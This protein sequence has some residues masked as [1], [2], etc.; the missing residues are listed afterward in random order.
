MTPG[1]GLCRLSRRRFIAA[2]AAA[3][4]AGPTSAAQPGSDSELRQSPRV[5]DFHTH[6]IEAGLAPVQGPLDRLLKPEAHLKDMDAL[7]IDVHV[8]GHSNAMQGIS[9]GDPAHDLTV[10]R[11]LNDR[12]ARDWVGK[13]PTRFVGAFGLPTQDLS[14]AIP[15]LE[16]SVGLGLKVLQISSQTPNGTYYGD[17]KLDPL[18]E[19]AEKLGVTLFIHPHG[20]AN[21]PPLNKFSLWNSVGQGIEEAKVMSSI[22]LE[23][24]FEKFPKIKIVV[25]HG[26]GFLPHYYG[27]LDRNA[28]KVA[29]APTI[30]KEPPSAYLKRF[31]YDSCVYAPAILEALV[32][33]VGHDR[34]VL[35]SDYPI[36][37][38]DPVAELRQTANLNEMQLRA[39]LGE[40]AAK[41]LG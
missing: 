3:S 12:I 32:K 26:G 2:A 16:R 21:G 33:V 6:I 15:E 35:G 28:A 14:L 4:A 8:V 11:R 7:G 13:Y 41:L 25:A 20:Q 39:I 10:W 1:C 23:G 29:A 24:I 38:N 19:A 9:W 34:I 36:G 30:N 18:F 5:I 17:P 31:Y 37:V 40:T 22:I 27:R